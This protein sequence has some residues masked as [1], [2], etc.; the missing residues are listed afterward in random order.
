MLETYALVATEDNWLSDCLTSSL[1]SRLE[2]LDEGLELVDFPLD[3]EEAY[4]EIIAGYPGILE[5][6][7]SLV[8][9][10][11]GLN[12]DQRAIVREAIETQNRFPDIFEAA[13]PCV[14][15]CDTLPEIHALARDLFEFSF[16]ALSR[17]KS[18]NS[19]VP[20]RDRQYGLVR[21]NLSKK[22]CPF[23]GLERLE[24]AHPDIPRPDLDHYLLVSRYPFCGV[25]LKN[26]APMGDR[27]NSSYKLTL[28][29]LHD[30]DGHRLE[31][32]DPYGDSTV[33][34]N[35]E[36]SDIFDDMGNGPRWVMNF[37]PNNSATANWNRMF[38]IDLRLEH[39]LNSEFNDWVKEIGGF[40]EGLDFDYQVID[41]LR[42]GLIRYRDVTSLESMRSIGRLKEGV[43]SLLL[44]SLNTEATQD[45]THAFLVDAFS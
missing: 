44:E 20:V 14:V 3:A 31:C 22:C 37:V 8:N 9:G 13:E 38:K 30:A 28:D 42:A 24:P 27:C 34:F 39:S 16:K 10:L 32:Y 17:I 41:E 23:C 2:C 11:L 26:L 18:P 35:I 36:D 43:A 5:R 29:V 6:F 15:C 7:G 19:D 33:S 21:E 4:R 45:R 40:I 1:L 12:A 25:N